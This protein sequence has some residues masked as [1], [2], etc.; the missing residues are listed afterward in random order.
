MIAA[1]ML[2]NDE[3]FWTPEDSSTAAAMSWGGSEGRYDDLLQHHRAL[4]RHISYRLD[5]VDTG[6]PSGR[7]LE[8]GA[9]MG[10]LDDL[11]DDESSIVM[12]DHTDR[13]ITA[14]PRPLRDR[15]RHLEWSQDT[16]AALQAEAGTFDWVIAIAVFFH[17]DDATAIALIRELGALLAPGGHVL[18]EGW[19]PA[20]KEVLHEM[21]VTER[22]FGR[23]PRY[24]LHLDLMRE[25]LWPD[26]HERCRDGILLYRKIRA[27]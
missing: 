22:L 9:G 7:I 18:I 23:Y 12:L 17:L 25:A 1:H 11:L 15:C 4:W 5:K 2:K 26:Y 27:T 6:P 24:A 8:F 14:R 10:F 19:N 20:T 16:L 21:A 13:F 3:S